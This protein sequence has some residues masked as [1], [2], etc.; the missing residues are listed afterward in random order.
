MNKRQKDEQIDNKFK[1][2][3]VKDLQKVVDVSQISEWTGWSQESVINPGIPVGGKKISQ[4]N[5]MLRLKDREELT[6]E[7]LDLRSQN[8]IQGEEIK[9]LKIEINKLK[10][11]STQSN[12]LLTS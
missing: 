10:K 2:K 7:I 12:K 1:S 4:L 8:N 6:K 5:E 3:M 9:L 11:K